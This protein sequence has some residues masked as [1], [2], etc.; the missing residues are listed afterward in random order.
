[1]KKKNSARDN[2]N[3]F[4]S[5][6]LL[7]AYIVCAYFFMNFAATLGG[8]AQAIVV[9]LIFV[10]FG[11]LLFYATRVG[12]GKSV[13]R[14]SV[15]TL[16]LLDLPALY[17]ILASIFTVLPLSQFITANPVIAYMAAVAFGYGI[18]YTFLSGFET[19]ECVSFDVDE[20]IDS[21]EPVEGGLEEELSEEATEEIQE[22]AED[23]VV[24]EGISAEEPEADEEVVEEAVESAEETE[25]ITE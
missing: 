2:L 6:F 22:E 15:I 5:A 18:P 4:F 14:F 13:V 17:A 20:I 7:V 12:D 9:A 11:L 8:V 1:M 21:I 24:V 10:V 16:V 23:E 3:L 19:V 25:E